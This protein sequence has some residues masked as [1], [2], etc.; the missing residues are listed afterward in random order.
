MSFLH[1]GWLTLLLLLPLILLG[2]ILT[3]RGRSKAWLCMVA[4]RLRQQ[5]VVESPMTRRWIALALTLLGCALTIMVIARPYHGETTVTEQI[6]SRN[7]LI[8]IDTSRSMLVQDVS[9]DRLGSAKIMALELISAFPD[10]RIGVMAFS[11]APV[12]MAP[13]TIDHTAVRESI[14]QLDTHVVPSGGSDLTLAVQLAIETFKKTGLKSNALIVISD[15]EDHS[16]KIQLAGSE[17]RDAGIAVCSIGVGQPGGGMIPDPRNADGKF[18]DIHGNP[19]HSR[20]NPEALEQLARAGGG[21]YL[22]ASSG[23]DNAIRQALAYLQSDQQSGRVTSIPLESYHWFLL[24][25]IVLFILSLVLRSS[26]LGPGINRPVA[27][28]SL[29]LLVLIMHQPLQAGTVLDQAW[30]AYQQQDYETAHQ[31]FGEAMQDA[32]GEDRHAI[33]FS[34]GSSAYK[35]KQWDIASRYFS[36]SLLSNNAT[37]KEESHYNLGNALFQSGWVIMN[38]VQPAEG[39]NPFLGPM[40]KLFNPQNPQQPGADKASLSKADLRRVTTYWQ[41]ALSHYREALHINPDNKHAGHNR[42]EVE[43]LLQQ[44]RDAEQQARQEAEQQQQDP[45]QDQQDQDGK[46]QDKGD[47]GDQSKQ[48]PEKEGD[49]DKN[50]KPDDRDPD[51]QQQGD[52]GQ[53]PDEEDQ[54]NQ[55]MERGADESEEAFA[56][57]ILKEQSDAETRPVKRRFLRL[58]R[59]EKDW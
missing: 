54:E 51:G 3:H 45:K 8:A 32:S 34:Q 40:R 4:P 2:A 11:G 27:A 43:K 24:P 5:L 56:A 23:A 47:E 33:Q 57:R 36:R 55:P 44:L 15:G 10:D 46:Q 38:P 6:R 39:E 41:D 17:I 50:G 16:E 59:P 21:T 13:L 48:D 58:R 53:H 35:L 29:A 1:P 7:I 52:P 22:A 12:V 20:L 42:R 37:L 31:L 30:D 14:K 26:L 25:A 18:R 9:P 19:V 28:A 49:P